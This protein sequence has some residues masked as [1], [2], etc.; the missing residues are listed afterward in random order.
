MENTILL[1]VHQAIRNTPVES[2]TTCFSCSSDT[3]FHIV[4]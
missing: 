4:S 3:P 2:T 1:G